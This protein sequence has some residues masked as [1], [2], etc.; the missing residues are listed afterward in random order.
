MTLFGPFWAILGHFGPFWAPGAQNDPI[1]GYF[2]CRYWPRLA[3]RAKMAQNGPKWPFLALW[4]PGAQIPLWRP[5]KVAK[6]AQNGPK[7]PKMAQNGHFGPFWAILGHFGPFWPPLMVS[8]VG[9]GPLGPRGPKR[10]ILGHFGPFWPFWPVWASTY[11]G[12]NPK[13]GHFGPLGPKMAQ[14]GPKWPKMGQKGSFWAN[15]PHV[16]IGCCEGIGPLGPGGQKGPFWPFW[17]LLASLGQYLQ[18]K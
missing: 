12:S 6:M 14:N 16:P 1:L 17:A 7:W 8:R 9:F 3:K 13:W 5:L 11:R 2:L 4:A 15:N 18:R 10:A